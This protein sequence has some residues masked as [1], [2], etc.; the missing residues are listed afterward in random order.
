MHL[1][2]RRNGVCRRRL[3]RRRRRTA[4]E[5]AFDECVDFAVQTF[6]LFIDFSNAFDQ[7]R[8]LL[9]IFFELQEKNRYYN[10]DFEQRLL[11]PLSHENSSQLSVRFRH[12]SF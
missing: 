2:K 8:Q 11:Y 9:L 7:I 3:L 6:Q 12:L 4:R 5:N 10:K 1:L